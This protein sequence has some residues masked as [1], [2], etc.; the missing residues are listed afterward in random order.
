MQPGESFLQTAV[1]ETK[2]ETGI[3]VT[4]RGVLRVEHTPRGNNHAR[5]RVIFFAEPVN[6]QQQPKQEADH[7]S[8]E[9]RWVTIDEFVALGRQRGPELVQ[10]GR[11]LSRGGT[12]YS[13][14][15]LGDENE[16]VRD[17]AE[18]G[19]RVLCN[20]GCFHCLQYLCCAA[21]EK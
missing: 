2:E 15:V 16:A 9:A 3:D 13:S 14:Q 12:V 5:M 17:P 7:K 10:W 1:R 11:Y 6:E 19:S 21:S 8:Q 18:G 20:Q 4:I